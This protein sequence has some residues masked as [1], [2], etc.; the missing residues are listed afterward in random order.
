[1]TT[2]KT[3]GA[4]HKSLKENFSLPRAELEEKIKALTGKI[5]GGKL[6]PDKISEPS[7]AFGKPGPGKPRISD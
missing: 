2:F 4:N 6:N 1:L 5:S 3:L 7:K